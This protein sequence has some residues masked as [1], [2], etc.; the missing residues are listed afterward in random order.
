MISIYYIVAAVLALV[1]VGAI[2]GPILARRR[3]TERLQDQFGS[4]YDRAVKTAGSEKEAQTELNG[5]RKHIESLN[6]RPLSVAER[7]RYMADW[8]TVQNK[9]V[10]Q[11][12]QATVEADHLIMEV[13]QLRD[14]PVSNFEQRAADISVQY[15]A[16]VSKYRAARAI[17]VLNE[18]HHAGTEDLR[19]AM[20]NYRSLFDELL[21]AETVAPEKA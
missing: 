20:I 4:E 15:P 10:D 3:H 2:L 1:V 14:Y 5:R 7:E 13:M 11:P 9:F 12:G 8:S 21:K 6:I 18:Q 19:Q 16:L 17:A